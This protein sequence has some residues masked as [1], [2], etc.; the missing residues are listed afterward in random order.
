MGSGAVVMGVVSGETPTANLPKWAVIF[1][2][3]GRLLITFEAVG[4]WGG[5]STALAFL[6]GQMANASLGYSATLEAVSSI[7]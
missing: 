7:F 3:V 1:V 5:R 2:M 4:E 6:G